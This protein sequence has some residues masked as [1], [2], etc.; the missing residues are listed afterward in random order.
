MG[1]GGQNDSDPAKDR[2]AENMS[3]E[4]NQRRR[5]KAAR[6]PKP[7]RANAPGAGIVADSVPV[8]E[9]EETVNKARVLLRAVEIAENG[10]V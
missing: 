8:L 7:T 10:A 2:V 3:L 1:D 6:P 5:R 9:F 4:N